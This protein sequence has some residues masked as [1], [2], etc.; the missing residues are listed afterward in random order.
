M[1]ELLRSGVRLRYDVVGPAGTARPP[2]LL[3]HGYSASA[4]MFG[5]TAQRLADE[6]R[7]ITWDMV[8]HG[9]SDYPADLAAYSADLAVADMVALLDAAGADRAVVA[10]H[11]LGG[12]LSLRLC[13]THP[14]RVAALVLIDTGP[15]YRNPQARA[16]WNEMAEN[17]AQGFERHGLAGLGA[18]EEVRA[19]VHRDATGL[20]LAARGILAQHDA[21]VIDSLAG[22]AVPTLVVVGENDTPFV[23]GSRYMAAKIPGAQ[24]VVVPGAGHAPNIEA[25][26]TFDPALRRFLDGLADLDGKPN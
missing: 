4:H 8:G 9:R 13:A 24:L 7:V 26:D 21:M 15:G 2:V 3:T 23:D 25:P 14:D 11:S 20:V 6:Y 18:S 17:F 5:T 19:D 22:I 12:F 10:G 16:G 1:A